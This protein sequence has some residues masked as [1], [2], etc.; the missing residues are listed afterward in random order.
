MDQ[1]RGDT[2]VR[3]HFGLGAGIYINKYA[4]LFFALK[5]SLFTFFL[6]KKSNKKIKANPNAPGFALAHAQI[7]ELLVINRL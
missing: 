2:K 5:C 3:C 7:P 1:E 6:D 4:V